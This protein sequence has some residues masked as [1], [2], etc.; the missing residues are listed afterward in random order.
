MLLPFA[1]P[2][3]VEPPLTLLEALACGATVLAA[4]DANRSGIVEHGR[5]GM[6]YDGEEALAARLVELAALGPEGRAALGDAGRELVVGTFGHAA[7]LAA[8]ERL[9]SAVGVS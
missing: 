4:P 8:L 5:T 6:T 3:A 7:A 1:A 2:V 9:W